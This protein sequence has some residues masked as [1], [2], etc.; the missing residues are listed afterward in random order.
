M[1]VDQAQQDCGTPS[2][3]CWRALSDKGYR[4]TDKDITADGIQKILVKGGDAER[5]KVLVKGKNNASK[6]Q[7]SLPTGIAAL[8]LNQ[9]RATVQVVTSDASCFGFTATD[10]KRADGSLFKGLGGSPS[11][12]FLDVTSDVLD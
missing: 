2:R 5:G 11:T 7:L 12:A 10:V 3:P 6:G 8:L 1:V 4:Y 9:T